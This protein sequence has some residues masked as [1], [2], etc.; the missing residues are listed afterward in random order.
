[1]TEGDVE[2]P[3]QAETHGER[4]L[5][6][7]VA[8]RPGDTAFVLTRAL[9]IAGEI[10]L[11]QLYLSLTSL[12]HRHHA[13]RKKVADVGGT[14]RLVNDEARPFPLTAMSCEDWTSEMLAKQIE[15]LA[16]TPIPLDTS[17][18]ARACLLKLEPDRHLLILSAHHLVCDLT[19]ARTLVG[20]LL[21]D[22]GSQQ[23]GSIDF[24][25]ELPTLLE[26]PNDRAEPVVSADNRWI[27][28]QAAS[29]SGRWDKSLGEG[30][31]TFS[32]DSS[33]QPFSV[34]LSAWAWISIR[35]MDA[36]EASF[37]IFSRGRALSEMRR[38]GQFSTSVDITL[39]PNADLPAVEFARQVDV[40]AKSRGLGRLG[41]PRTE[42]S[43]ALM[44][45]GFQKVR[46]DASEFEAAFALGLV[47]GPV[48]H[49]AL[50]IQA[51]PV[52]VP[53]ISGRLCLCIAPACDGWLWRADF[54]RALDRQSV[55]SMLNHLNA[56]LGGM[57]AKPSLPLH[58][59]PM[60]S[61]G[62]S[63]W[64]HGMEIESKVGVIDRIAQQVENTPERVAIIQD[65]REWSYAQLWE[66]SQAVADR[67]T[68]LGLLA[69]N[70]IALA[71]EPSIESVAA[72]VGIMRAGAAFMPVPTEDAW[73]R[74]QA[75]LK[76]AKPAMVLIS[77]DLADRPWGSTHVALIEVW[78]EE[79]AVAQVLP[80]P[81]PGDTAYVIHTSGSTGHPKGVE[82]SRQNL[83]GFMSSITQFLPVSSSDR[84][85]LLQPHTF[86]ISLM[87]ALLPLTLGATAVV[88][89]KFD[90]RD[91]RQMADTLR[92]KRI[93]VMQATP[94]LWAQLLSSG[95]VDGEGLLAICGGEALQPALAE[96]LIRTHAQVWNFY[97]P[98]EATIWCS[99]ARVTDASSIHLGRPLP[100]YALQ[101]MDEDSSPTPTGCVG[102]LW[103]GGVGVGLG[104][105]LDPLNTRSRFV[106]DPENPGARVYRTGDRVRREPDGRMVY[107]G[108]SDHQVK[109]AG[110]RVEL[111]EVEGALSDLFGSSAAVLLMQGETGAHLAAVVEQPAGSVLDEQAVR[112]RLRDVLAPH[113]VPR[114]I[115]AVERLPT[116]TNGKRDS[117][118]LREL[119]A[120]ASVMP[121]CEPPIADDTI[122]AVLDI[123]G[124]VLGH[125]VID[126]DTD[127]FSAGGQSLDLMRCINIMEQ[128]FGVRVG[129]DALWR[130]PSASTAAEHI[131]RL[132]AQTRLPTRPDIPA[133]AGRC[134][135]TAS[136]RHLWVAHQMDGTGV[137]YSCP[138]LLEIEGRVEA[139]DL[140]AVLQDVAVKHPALNCRFLIE[141]G[142]L[143]TLSAPPAFPLTVRHSNGDPDVAAEWI[144]TELAQRI[145][146]E[147][148]PLAKALW[149]DEGQGGLLLIVVHHV[150]FDGAS[151]AVLV[152]D[153]VQGLRHR[154]AGI[155]YLQTQVSTAGARASEGGIPS[156]AALQA[157]L[158]LWR[159][160]LNGMLPDP[161]RTGEI[162]QPEQREPRTRR[163]DLSERQTQC[164]RRQ[165]RLA[166][167]SFFSFL[168]ALVLRVL[169]ESTGK[170]VQ[171]LTV[172][173]S[174]R[175]PGQDGVGMHVEQILVACKI[176]AGQPLT[177]IAKSVHQGMG[178]AMASFVP[179]DMLQKAMGAGRLDRIKLAELPV[180]VAPQRV[181]SALV[182]HPRT[183][184]LSPPRH[185]ITFHF[186]TG[187]QRTTI[188][189]ACDPAQCSAKL[190]MA[191]HDL[192]LWHAQAVG[193]FQDEREG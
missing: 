192:L 118:G 56:H 129:I 72:L 8:M 21:A 48:S 180:D 95:W 152:G 108:R 11:G 107:L 15:E 85:Y 176:Y 148:G 153:L 32:R 193:D 190:E 42:R 122:R 31:E 182:I 78:L 136:Q 51:W 38:T 33:V 20:E 12:V 169:Y 128:H 132:Q 10:S 179:L 58:A 76:A 57:L 71:S 177:D 1:M 106:D 69:G 165:A 88:A 154:R 135:A 94:T 5:L 27:S 167:M 113:M 130:R 131:I 93:T 159:Q 75:L 19:S 189:L 156:P 145:D 97:G 3:Y 30:I 163:V 105:R 90:R 99:A 140:R 77:R 112:A 144:E 168:A 63:Q 171:L 98:T 40:L 119:A 37:A 139:G 155:P 28:R 149:I 39:R 181:D 70:V 172:D 81:H 183:D 186:L 174:T 102:E 86:D 45:F 6:D 2:L 103:V 62:E 166:S 121:V 146:L 73:P 126:P 157:L 175:G 185:D 41:V 68:G 54:D 47:S 178:E 160:R 124:T 109:I 55:A 158:E 114:R 36:S 138:L 116:L 59:V 187:G 170:A 161:D 127:F 137:L 83:D 134:S 133:A 14:L 142:V 100:G 29:I 125:R 151:T 25:S 60:L 87:E 43:R 61:P 120:A 101:V 173:V 84:F 4:E 150:V 67:L 49:G 44:H 104:Y 80:Q 89:S 96:A 65:S 22:L 147:R 7:A 162:A 46:R 123:W 74:M 184:L 9:A 16:D 24:Q 115:L 35:H 17:P 117:A 18:L 111:G 110:Q 143:L 191:V 26:A 164:L 13:L 141:A 79:P 188:L 23:A 64:L 52:P 50:S 66:A 82:I 53:R 34:I 92:A 91:P